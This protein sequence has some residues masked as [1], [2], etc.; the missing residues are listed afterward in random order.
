MDFAAE[1]EVLDWGAANNPEQRKPN[2]ARK[3]VANLILEI[4]CA[5]ICIRSA[6]LSEPGCS[7]PLGNDSCQK[8]GEHA[9]AI[10]VTQD[11][12]NHILA[13]LKHPH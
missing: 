11:F 9:V 7:V 4:G 6:E 3:T 8:N 10:R 1:L 13:R 2:V 12:K 5:R